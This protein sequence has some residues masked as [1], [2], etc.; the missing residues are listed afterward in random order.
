[1]KTLA[2]VVIPIIAPTAEGDELQSLRQCLKVLNRWDIHYICSRELDTTFYEQLN[3]E[4]GV[5]F[6]KCTFGEE[7]FNGVKAYN[8]LC[9]SP[10][11]Y[12]TFERYEYML[13]YQLDAY[14]FEDRLEEWCRRGYDYIG[15]PWLCPWSAAVENLDHWEVGNGGFCLRNVQTF[16]RVLTTPRLL[17]KPLKGMNRFRYENRQRLKQKPWLA[18]W[19]AF[20]AA[21][22]WHN[23][24]AYYI[25]QNGQEDKTFAQCQYNGLMRMPDA[26]EAMAFSFDMRPA[27]CYK[28]TGNRLPM[29][30]HMWFKYDNETFWYPQIYRNT[31]G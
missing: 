26:R 3:A 19:L 20:R 16:I 6:S 13:I 25:K 30:C 28:L 1:M 18:L 8:R 22:G 5:P 4:H 12:E 10:M 29:G 27:T 31:N 17:H 23:T 24:L 15:G 21:S 11:L 7:W 9:F 14:V 2:T